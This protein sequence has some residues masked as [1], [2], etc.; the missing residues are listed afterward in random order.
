MRYIP[1]CKQ[2]E[3]WWKIEVNVSKKA[4]ALTNSKA[5]DKNGNGMVTFDEIVQR[6]GNRLDKAILKKIFSEVDVNKVWSIIY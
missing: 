2:K 1:F 5:I 3:P 4:K 6:Y